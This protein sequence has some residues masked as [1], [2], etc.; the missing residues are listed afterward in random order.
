MMGAKHFRIMTEQHLAGLS[1]WLAEQH[2][3]TCSHSSDDKINI[4]NQSG[5]RYFYRASIFVLAPH[6]FDRAWEIAK[7]GTVNRSALSQ[8][9]RA[10]PSN[11]GDK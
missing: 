7:A 9:E 10:H 11:G 8:P 6:L 3:N 2:C 5:R 1:R 4:G